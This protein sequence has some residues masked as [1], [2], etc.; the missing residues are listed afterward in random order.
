MFF[1]PTFVCLASFAAA[2]PVTPR[3]GKNAFPCVWI[4]ANQHDASL[5]P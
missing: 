5:E 1:V 3:T 4:P 2:R